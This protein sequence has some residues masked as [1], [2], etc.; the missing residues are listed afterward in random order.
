MS[1]VPGSRRREDSFARYV[2]EEAMSAERFAAWAR[3]TVVLFFLSLQ[4]LLLLLSFADPVSRT[5]DLIFVG[6]ELLAFVYAAGVL[7]VLRRA[8]RAAIGYVTTVVD[9]LFLTIATLASVAPTAS[10]E[11]PTKSPVTAVYFLLVAMSGLRLSPRLA[12][13]GG[14]CAA[15]AY[16]LLLFPALVLRP[17]RV[18]VENIRD[19]NADF[20][21]PV[22]VVLVAILMMAAGAL[23]AQA[24]QLARSAAQRSLHTVTF[25]FTDIRG[26]TAYVEAHGDEA[27]ADLVRDYRDLV[28]TNVARYRGRELKTAGDSVLVEFATSQQA[29]QC[30][31]AIL[32]AAQRRTA[33]GLEAP[34]PFG[35]GLHAGEPVR[36]EGDYL[37]SAVNVAARLCEQAAAGELLVTD[38]VRGLVRTSGLPSTRER[39]GLTLKGISDAPRVYAVDWRGAG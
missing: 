36:I 22:R 18:S 21:N 9:I 15:L 30:A 8:Y 5:S 12:L 14:A 1:R 29:L 7:A 23:T 6:F 24:S 10:Y 3:L 31:I 20:V 37:G 4:V 39:E 19:Y 34:L 32:T 27:G 25:L 35:I 16:L 17:E 33:D 28:R 38:V 2:L 13:F 26:Y 11:L